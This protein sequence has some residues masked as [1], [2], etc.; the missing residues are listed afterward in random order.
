M[1]EGAD[2]GKKEDRQKMGVMAGKALVEHGPASPEPEQMDDSM[3]G[4][5]EGKDLV[6][7]R[8]RIK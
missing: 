7:V 6:M 8:V 3:V 5:G 4:S 1:G 2:Y